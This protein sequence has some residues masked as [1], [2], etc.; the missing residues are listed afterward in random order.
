MDS[1]SQKRSRTVSWW[2]WCLYKSPNTFTVRKVPLLTRVP[3]IFG[4]TFCIRFLL[5]KSWKSLT[6]KF[7]F[8]SGIGDPVYMVCHQVML[9]YAGAVWMIKI[10]FSYFT[11]TDPLSYSP[12]PKSLSL[13]IR[14]RL[15]L[16]GHWSRF[17]IFN[18]D[19]RFTSIT[20]SE[21]PI[22]TSN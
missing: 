22:N 9:R 6:R 10:W 7:F 3:Q 14:P 2:T 19:R 20:C 18:N 4:K 21:C 11:T 15:R 13:K 12:F 16:K 5:T 1:Q 17:R 8:F